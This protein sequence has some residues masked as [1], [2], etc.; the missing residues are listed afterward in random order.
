MNGQPTMRRPGV[1]IGLILLSITFSLVFG[2]ILVR[3]ALEPGNFLPATLISDPI[4][5]SRIKP[6]TTGH[7][8][9]GFRNERVPEQADV[10]AVGDSQTYGVSAT[11]DGSWPYQLSKL[12]GRT[13]YSMALGGY[14][15]VDY[16]YLIQ[17]LAPPLHAK[18][19]IV[20]IYLGND[21][22]EACRAV[23]ARPYWSAWRS[24]SPATCALA[25]DPLDRLDSAKR[26][27]KL[28]TWLA[29][30]SVL[31]GVV[32]ATI[33]SHIITWKKNLTARHAPPDLQ[34]LWEDQANPSVHTIFTPQYR[35]SV[36]DPHLRGVQEGLRI[37]KRALREMRDATAQQGARLL[38]VLIPTKERVYCEYLVKSAVLLPPA[39][40]RL[41]VAEAQVADEL[42][43]FLTS[44]GIPYVDVSGPMQEQAAKHLRMYPTDSDGHPIATGYGVI[45][46]AIST[47]LKA[48]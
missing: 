48:H 27:G 6:N 22:L 8:A 47:A 5:G 29:S 40:G 3:L 33:G 2:E 46:G 30:H 16:L 10:L 32:K 20:G 25:D 34:M 9:L 28:R 19:F 41:C 21:L 4:L 35:L 1:A 11:R 24:D 17:H 42:G 38:I 45:A 44:E 13:V 14:S 12:L 39:Y 26:F 23:E 31:Y 18:Q 36:L 7:D 43:E 37:T 15:P